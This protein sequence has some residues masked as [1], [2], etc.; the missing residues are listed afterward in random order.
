MNEYFGLSQLIFE[1]IITTYFK[2]TEQFITVILAIEQMSANLRENI[3]TKKM[4]AVI[5]KKRSN[6]E[7]MC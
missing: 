1:S 4:N 5:K 3:R 2:K 6:N 7:F